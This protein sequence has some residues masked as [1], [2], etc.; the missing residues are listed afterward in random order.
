MTLHLSASQ[1]KD[2]RNCVAD[3]GPPD[4]GRLSY[5]KQPQTKIMIRHIVFFTAASSSN[6]EPILDGL[7]LLTK[8]PHAR[9][10]EVAQNRKSDPASK[11]VDVIVYCEFGRMPSSPPIRRIRYIRTLSS[12]CGRCAN[13][14][15]RPTMRSLRQGRRWARTRASKYD[16]L[17]AGE[18]DAAQAGS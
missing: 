5:R 4:T 11:E 9:R 8:I 14:G 17:V 7:A 3:L 10:L 12:E 18:A 13:C 2:W 1:L 6:L 15:L 16:A